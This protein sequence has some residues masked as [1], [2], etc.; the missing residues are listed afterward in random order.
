MNLF[1]PAPLTNRRIVGLL[2]IFITWH[3]EQKQEEG[4]SA[5]QPGTTKIIFIKREADKV[6]FQFEAVAPIT[7]N[8]YKMTKEVTVN[9]RYPVQEYADKDFYVLFDFNELRDTINIDIEPYCIIYDDDAELL[10]NGDFKV[11]TD[12]GLHVEATPDGLH[13]YIEPPLLATIQPYKQLAFYSI[14]GIKP[15]NGNIQIT[16]L[17]D[18]VLTGVRGNSA[19]DLLET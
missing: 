11:N 16:G 4:T 2:D 6:T 17:G 7:T 12:N 8:I 3:A 5:I 14:N 15:D 18:T 13:F 9:P 1:N 19:A 10:Y